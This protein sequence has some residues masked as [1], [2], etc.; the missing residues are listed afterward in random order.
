MS[1]S[2]YIWCGDEKSLKEVLI[3]VNSITGIGVKIIT[4]FASQENKPPH[5]KVI[6]EVDDRT[7]SFTIENRTLEE[8]KRL[9]ERMM[10][11][12]VNVFDE[13]EK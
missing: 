10:I 5:I 1:R 7:L 3:D 6:I 11:E 12:R 4:I 8:V 13:E 9:C 2:K